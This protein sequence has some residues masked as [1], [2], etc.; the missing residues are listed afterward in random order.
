MG[1]VAVAELVRPLPGENRS[2]DATRVW[3]GGVRT[4][5]CLVD[6]TGHGPAAAEAAEAILQ[7]VD[8]HLQEPICVILTGCDQ[9][10]RATRG[11]AVGIAIID[12]ASDRVEYGGIGNTRAVLHRS[13]SYHFAS[14][15]GIVG[16][17]FRRCLTF[18]EEIRDG[19]F[20]VL[21]T[22]GIRSR[23]GFAT[24]N[25]ASRTSAEA[26][27]KAV[28][29]NFAQGHDDAAVIAVRYSKHTE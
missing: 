20:L 14:A 12:T 24:L 7:Y 22:D 1:Q 23:V 21:M 28:I 26:L 8:A 11:G 6:G 3:S 16:G 19:D 27:A 10:V 5:L 4:T 2:G 13:D 15:P 9:A 18:S 17:G 29:S 25:Y